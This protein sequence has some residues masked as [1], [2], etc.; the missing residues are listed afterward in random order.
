MEPLT[1]SYSIR[2]STFNVHT[3]PPTESLHDLLG[4]D[5]DFY[6]NNKL[7]SELLPDVFAVGLQEV[8]D[9]DSWVSAV[10]HVLFPWDT[11]RIHQTR[12]SGILLLVYCKRSIIA[13]IRRVKCV[14]VR[15][16]T[17]KG[18]LVLS[19]RISGV[20]LA[21]IACHLTAHPDK[22]R[23]RIQ[24]YLNILDEANFPDQV[25]SILSHDYAIW[26]GD[27][28]FR[29]NSCFS[30]VISLIRNHH[31]NLD[32]VKD[33]RIIQALIEKDQLTLARKSGEAFSEFNEAEVGF[34]PTYKYI[35]FT[36]KLDGS[37]V[38]SYTDRILFRFTP[39]AYELIDDK[40]RLDMV[41]KGYQSHERYL[42]SDHKPVSASFQFLAFHGIPHINFLPVSWTLGSQKDVWFT[43]RTLIPLAQDVIAIVKSSFNS[44]DQITYQVSVQPKESKDIP[45]R[46]SFS[47]R[48]KVWFRVS[49]AGIVLSQTES[50]SL[51]YLRERHVLGISPPFQVDL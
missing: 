38:P 27:L 8:N 4:F 50:Y 34:W 48:E 32:G 18:A 45:P 1:S 16:S 15:T 21:L 14:Q 37:R 24:E 17:T 3:S 13:S 10:D 6:G 5:L 26:F 12:M 29:V 11:V 22:L 46:V 28:N 33:K 2:V 42:L 19:L 30:E 7:N 31:E 20:S 41:C 23:N 49:F 35:P 43:T 40:I 47:Q 51:L 39:N 36:E 44:L 9:Y 25:Q